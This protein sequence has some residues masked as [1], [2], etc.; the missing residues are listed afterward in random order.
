MN[1]RAIFTWWLILEMPLPFEN[2]TS[3]RR[4]VQ[5]W[6]AAGMTHGPMGSWIFFNDPDFN[7]DVPEVH[8][9]TV[10]C[11]LDKFR[12]EDVRHVRDGSRLKE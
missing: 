12:L 9:G 5:S 3:A 7:P 1:L 11:F 10:R 6:I 8:G 4:T 2:F